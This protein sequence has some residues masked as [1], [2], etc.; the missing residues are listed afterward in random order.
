MDSINQNQPE[1]NHLDL[2]RGAAVEK[3]KEIVGK[4]KSC[5]FCTH[6]PNGA[7]AGARP[8]S[9]REVDEQGRLWFLSAKD[10]HKNLE[11]ASDADVALYFQA[12]PH[13]DFMHLHG[14]ARVTTDRADIERL[15]EPILRTWFTGGIEDERIT[16]IEVTPVEGYYWDTK[17]GIAVA[18][19]KMLIGA[20]TGN[21]FDDSIE[22]RLTV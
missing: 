9:V 11:L 17:H 16:V 10:S 20:M 12:S 19:V 7:T 1:A 21:T 4:S 15:W 13:S 22:G 6:E 14:R 18:G 3:I 5:F 2:Q 8:M